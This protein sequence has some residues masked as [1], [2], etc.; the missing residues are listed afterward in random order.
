MV[1][2]LCVQTDVDARDH[3]VVV[4]KGTF[5]TDDQ[6]NLSL[7]HEQRPLV[8]TDE[9]YGEPESSCVKY[10]SDF[11]Q[12]KPLTDVIVVGK[13]VSPGGHPIIELLVRLE[14]AGWSKDV[15]V[16]G[17][18]RW[19]RGLAELVPSR[20]VPFVE[21]PLTFD[22]AF[23]GQDDSKGPGLVAAELRNLAGVGLHVHRDARAIEGTSLP[24]LE[25]P[26]E[27]ISSR[28]DRPQP[29]GFGCMGRSWKPRSDYAGTYDAKWRDEVCPFLPK[30]FDSR[31]FQCAPPDQQFPRFR[32]GE[33]I[34]CLHMAERVVQYTIPSLR[35]P[36][37]FEFE[38]AE[39]SRLGE[40]DT[41]VLEPHRYQ[42][43][44]VWRASVPLGKRLVELR[45][46][47]VGEPP[48]GVE[49]TVLG[50]RRGKPV[51]AGIE[52]TIRWLRRDRGQTS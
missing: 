45:S 2:D 8:H 22:R 18:R 21:M 27:R 41:I 34:R 5:D 14:L 17:E 33:V 30:D 20:P 47:H 29:I 38:G 48:R 28:R 50:H 9:H 40:L 35:I 10:E 51:F 6:G 11:A 1:A 13:A 52:A 15:L 25:D 3:C 44:L 42:A 39:Q 32:G 12:C 19:V 31:Y 24:N 16:V 46:I 36:V 23:G 43:M 49:H 4:V 7:A 37:R 26:R